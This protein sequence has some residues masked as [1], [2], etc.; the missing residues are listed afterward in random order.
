MFS[1]VTTNADDVY[2]NS[3][4]N[5]SLNRQSNEGFKQSIFWNHVIGFFKNK[6]AAK[7]AKRFPLTRLLTIYSF[8]LKDS[9][10][11]P[12][13]LTTNLGLCVLDTSLVKADLVQL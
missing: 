1:D 8:Q 10:P 13:V 7:S 6:L 4:K 9:S 12:R 2:L 3:S 11:L 5:K